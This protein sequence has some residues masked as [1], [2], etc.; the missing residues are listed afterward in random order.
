[1]SYYDI[2]NLYNLIL[3]SDWFIIFPIIII[4]IIGLIMYHVIQKHKK[5]MPIINCKEICMLGITVEINKNNIY[6]A[7]KIY[8]E[9]VTRKIGIPFQDDDV[10][11]EVYDSWYNAFG[12]IRELLKEIPLNR[13]NIQLKEIVIEILNEG[14]RPHLTKWQAKFRAWY[15]N[16]V[17]EESNR[18]L[19]P[20][21]IQKKYKNYD[22]LVKDLKE[23][24]NY[25]IELIK[26]LR[27]V[28]GIMEITT[29]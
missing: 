11:N 26:K 14:M 25:I 27:D 12:E 16:A 20:Q 2:K 28:L 24:Q 10:I 15:N 5:N 7:Y 6:A 21:D 1:M 18:K 4:F 22:E 8:V 29:E 3:N 19:S 23:G 13:S 17:T 9:L